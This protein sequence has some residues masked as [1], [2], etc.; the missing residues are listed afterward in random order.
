MCCF[1]YTFLSYIILPENFPKNQETFSLRPLISND[2]VYWN[3]TTHEKQ[4][5]SVLQTCRNTLRT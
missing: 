2:A 4:L 3:W 5:L 1:L